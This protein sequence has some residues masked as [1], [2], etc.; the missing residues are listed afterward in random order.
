VLSWTHALTGFLPGDNLT[1]GTLTITA[2]NDPST[3]NQSF[4]LII[5]VLPAITDLTVTDA[6]TLGSPDS[7]SFPFATYL[8]GKLGDGVLNLT[9]TS[10]NGNHTFYFA[11]SVL[12]VA[13]TRG[14]T[15]TTNIDVVATP[16]PPALPA[17]DG[18]ALRGNRLR[19]RHSKAGRTI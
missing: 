10:A 3:N 15:G 14:E 12:E 6:S 17:G 5:D 18:L 8:V 9:L 7:F 19:S 16:S 13:G 4:D 2:Y 1:S 11:K